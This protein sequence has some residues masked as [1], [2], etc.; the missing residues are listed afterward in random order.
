MLIGHHILIDWVRFN[1]EKAQ[2]AGKDVRYRLEANSHM[3][4]GPPT[5][6]R[7]ELQLAERATPAVRGQEVAGGR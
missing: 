2:G 6:Y 3:R 7:Y 1:I 4:Q 5:F